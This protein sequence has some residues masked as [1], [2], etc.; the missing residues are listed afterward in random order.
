MESINT[1]HLTLTKHL[2]L[3]RRTTSFLLINSVSHCMALHTS[4]ATVKKLYRNKQATNILVHI[5]QA[6]GHNSVEL[7]PPNNQ[8]AQFQQLLQC[9]DLTYNSFKHC[10]QAPFLE[11]NFCYSILSWITAPKIPV[12][13]NKH[14]YCTSPNWQLGVFQILL[15]TFCKSRGSTWLYLRYVKKE[16][17]P[18]S[19][20][21]LLLLSHSC[22]YITFFLES[23]P[24]FFNCLRAHFAAVHLAMR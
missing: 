5:T 6:P 4:H 22:N 8:H 21:T 2:H 15:Q 14:N 24:F 9:N 18:L 23:K 10:Q 16:T 3:P 1:K 13:Q 20:Y 7:W 17:T 12:P 19:L 11:H